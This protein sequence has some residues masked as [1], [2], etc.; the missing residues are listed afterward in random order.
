M[1]IIHILSLSTLGYIVYQDIKFRAISWW[2]FP[3]LFTLFILQETEI[4]KSFQVFN[5][6]LNNILILCVLIIAL[7]VY[8]SIK[9]VS[10]KNLFKNYLGIGDLLILIIICA[11]FSTVNY[12]LFI[13]VSSILSIALHSIG[14]L[15]K[16]YPKTVPFAAFISLF[17]IILEIMKLGNLDLYNY[18]VYNL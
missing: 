16:N 6:L 1:F 10:A 4:F 12:L 5:T 9:G 7:I 3:V 14:K 2:I 18:P 8:Y 11:R 15:F 13:I 17:L